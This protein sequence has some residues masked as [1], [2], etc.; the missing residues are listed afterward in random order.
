MLVPHSEKK[1][2]NFQ[3]SNFTLIFTMFLVFL[4]VATSVYAIKIHGQTSKRKNILET[5]NN[6]ITLKLKNFSELSKELELKQSKLKK[7]LS[8]L[9][10][11][12]G[13]Y[14]NTEKNILK[15][16]PI[17]R[18]VY[19]FIKNGKTEEIAYIKSIYTLQK[20][21]EKIKVLNKRLSEVKMQ[22]Q[23]F[24]K[25]IR[26]IPSLWPIYGGSGIY[27]SGYGPRIDPFTRG[28][29]FHSGV[30]ILAMPGYPIRA[31]ADGIVEAAE[32]HHGNGLYVN[33]RHKYSYVTNYSH[34]QKFVVNKGDI[35]KKG[36]II[37][38]I[39][40]TGRSTGYHL[41]YEVRINANHINPNPFLYL[42]KFSK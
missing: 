42:D 29:S 5:E 16:P 1:I 21:I 30:D 4:L 26:D 17:P 31:T 15:F 3:I 20:S 11:K 25:I 14:L 19:T 35:V 34:M 10:K 36:D 38:Y 39:G 6:S 12:A 33:I 7:T 13:G 23:G 24:K 28:S 18:Q 22:I 32:Y 40:N 27:A 9:I 8:A 41:H 37:G 2:F